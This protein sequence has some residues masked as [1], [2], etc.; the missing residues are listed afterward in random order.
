MKEIYNAYMVFDLDKI[1]DLI[2]DVYYNSDLE[3]SKNKD[4][5]RKLNALNKYL[6]M[7]YKRWNSVLSP[8]LPFTL[9][10]KG[11]GTMQGVQIPIY[12]PKEVIDLINYKIVMDTYKK[13]NLGGYRIDCYLVEGKSVEEIKEDIAYLN[14]DKIPFL[15]IGNKLYIQILEPRE[16][17]RGSFANQ[18]RHIIKNI[19]LTVNG[20][21]LVASK[22]II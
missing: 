11:H 2:N 16:D 21:E 4:K 9:S 22:R 3:D 15:Y 14:G 18:L 5:I 7:R 10:I 12:N 6:N 20:L 19:D 8:R 1:K 17:N 13:D